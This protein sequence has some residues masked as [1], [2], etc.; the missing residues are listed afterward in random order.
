M[1]KECLLSYL[2]IYVYLKRSNRK[3]AHWFCISCKNRS[4]KQ[5]CQFQMTQIY[6]IYWCV[7]MLCYIML[8]VIVYKC[9]CPIWSGSGSLKL[10]RAIKNRTRKKGTK[11]LKFYFESI[12][13]KDGN[14]INAI[15]AINWIICLWMLWTK[16]SLTRKKIH[17]DMCLLK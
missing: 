9:L 5:I 13:H 7:C 16:H 3:P 17:V 14:T 12:S 6:F 1:K 8:C 11:F 10:Y 2:L 15:Y 4:K